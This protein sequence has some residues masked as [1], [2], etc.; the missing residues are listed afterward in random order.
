MDDCIFCKIINNEIPSY[1]IY[2]DDLVM[3]FLDISQVSPGHTLVIPKNHAANFLELEPTQ[4]GQLFER[5]N[6]ITKQLAKKLGVKEFNI[7]NNCGET[8][9][10]TV[11]HVHVH[12]IP[13]YSL[14]DK[15]VLELNSDDSVKI[16]EIYEK[17]K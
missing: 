10:Q 15:L 13:R 6:I 12:I 16:E 5:V 3:A 7:I 1:K 9:G 4:A 2:E 8:A 14:N 11:F 17:L